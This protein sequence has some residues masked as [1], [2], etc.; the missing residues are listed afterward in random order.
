MS[1]PRRDQRGTFEAKASV[2]PGSDAGLAY[3][4]K[5]PLALAGFETLASQSH[6][7]TF[8]GPHEPACTSQL[9]AQGHVPRWR[10]QSFAKAPSGTS[11]S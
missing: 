6:R 8:P 3:R 9:A 1:L 4:K 10:A 11:R 2:L 5:R 7:Y